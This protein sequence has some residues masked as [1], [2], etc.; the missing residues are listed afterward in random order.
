MDNFE[1][2]VNNAVLSM[3][4]TEVK[5][6]SFSVVTD[7]RMAIGKQARIQVVEEKFGLAEKPARIRALQ[8][9]SSNARPAC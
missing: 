2:N 1:V 4:R 3:K 5:N 6:S 7:C 8:A 9:L